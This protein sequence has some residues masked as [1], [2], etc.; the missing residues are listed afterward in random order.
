MWLYFVWRATAHTSTLEHLPVENFQEIMFWW[1]GSIGTHLSLCQWIKYFPWVW[2]SPS[3]GV[4]PEMTL[5]KV[6]RVASFCWCQNHL[7]PRNYLSE[8]LSLCLTLNMVLFTQP[9]CVCSSCLH[10]EILTGIS[11]VFNSLG[12]LFAEALLKKRKWVYN[13]GKKL[14]SVSVNVSVCVCKICH[15]FIITAML[16]LFSGK[17]ESSRCQGLNIL[18]FNSLRAIFKWN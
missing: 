16:A 1:P 11:A 6:F 12:I 10:K 5:E 13:S 17:A 2:L 7:S 9:K 4:H 8:L 3:D 14:S 15:V 18:F